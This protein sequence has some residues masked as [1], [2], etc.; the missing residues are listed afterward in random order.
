V[1]ADEALRLGLVSEVCS[2]DALLGRALE[3]A[4]QIARMPRHATAETKRRILFDGERS[5]GALFAEEERVFRAALLGG[6]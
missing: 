2:T 1:G 3:L 4:G 5:W 6:E